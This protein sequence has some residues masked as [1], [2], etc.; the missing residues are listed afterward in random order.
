M[1]YLRSS[2]LLFFYIARSRFQIELLGDSTQG[3]IGFLFLFLVVNRH[4]HATTS[5]GTGSRIRRAS[6]IRARSH[7]TARTRSGD[8][9]R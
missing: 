4:F 1:R 3:L 8:R 5:G 7:R 2:R 6:L 9:S